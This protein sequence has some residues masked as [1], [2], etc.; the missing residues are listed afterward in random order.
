MMSFRIRIRVG[1]LWGDGQHQL[2]T[3]IVF[4]HLQIGR[5][6]LLKQT[7]ILWGHRVY[8]GALRLKDNFLLTLIAPNYTS[9]LFGIYLGFFKI[10]VL[11]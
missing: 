9:T 3:R 10:V 2:S 11:I 1:E 5:I 6:E 4:S 8:V 7:R